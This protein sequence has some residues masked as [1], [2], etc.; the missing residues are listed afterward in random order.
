M[1]E[2]R[3][4]VSW[5]SLRRPNNFALLFVFISLVAYLNL[6]CCTSGDNSNAHTHNG[7]FA[8]RR[9]GF[10]FGQKSSSSIKG[11][12]ASD[13][14]KIPSSSS[15][16]NANK[17]NNNS[18]GQAS[19][20]SEVIEPSSSN[21]PIRPSSDTDGNSQVVY[22]NFTRVV[23]D[24]NGRNETT[25]LVNDN[26]RLIKRDVQIVCGETNRNGKA[27]M[28]NLSSD[29]ISNRI[30]GGSKAEPGEF[31][32]QVRLNIRSRRGSSLCGGVIMDKRHILTAAHC[33]TTW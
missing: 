16:T 33:V 1:V 14:A 5:L 11:T 23:N 22:V 27:S 26:E 3:I 2:P 21:D 32:Y 20:P 13:D 15:K 19:K 10:K 31:P 7:K 18:T 6:S 30:V 9:A 24:G 28:D 4:N 12:K 29:S 25:R 8:D 17:S